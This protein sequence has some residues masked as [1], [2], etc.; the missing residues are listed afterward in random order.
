MRDEMGSIPSRETTTP[1]GVAP[2]GDITV[3]VLLV[4][5]HAPS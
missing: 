4:G 2:T 5:S 3:D 1:P